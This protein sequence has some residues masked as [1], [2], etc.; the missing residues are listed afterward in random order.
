LLPS[1]QHPSTHPSSVD[2][3]SKMTM[4]PFLP[5]SYKDTEYDGQANG[6]GVN[7]THP[8]IFAETVVHTTGSMDFTAHSKEVRKFA[9][10]DHQAP[11]VTSN[12]FLSTDMNAVKKSNK[13]PSNALSKR[14]LFPIKLHI[15]LTNEINDFEVTQT[16]AWDDHGRSFRVFRKQMFEECVLPR[17][18]GITKMKSFIR[19]L[20]LY[21]FTRITAGRDHGSYYHVNFLRG[22]PELCNSIRREKTRYVPEPNFRGKLNHDPELYKL[23]VVGNEKTF[24]STTKSAS[25]HPYSSFGNTEDFLQR[26][27]KSVDLVAANPP[28]PPV[29][30][31]NGHPMWCRNNFFGDIGSCDCCNGLGFCRRRHPMWSNQSF[32]HEQFGN[33]GVVRDMRPHQ[34]Y[35]VCQHGYPEWVREEETHNCLQGPTTESYLQYDANQRNVIGDEFDTLFD[36]MQEGNDCFTF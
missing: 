17:L 32:F 30:N 3:H 20:N 6:D 2:S 11:E 23:P 28:A 8:D 14:V 24:T 29:M 34:N 4:T 18:F 10:V 22:Y 31:D 35:N 13:K 16:I 5:A 33:M 26:Q 15:L 12:S 25:T 1:Q 27:Q 19:Q 21:N 36:V 7:L 9:N